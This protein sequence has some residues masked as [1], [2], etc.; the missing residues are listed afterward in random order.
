MATG[1]RA[2]D[3]ALMPSI[4]GLRSSCPCDDTRRRDVWTAQRFIAADPPAVLAS[5]TDPELIMLWA[6]IDF[7]VGGLRGRRLRGGSHAIVNG[8]LAGVTAE[9]EV[10]VLRA[11]EECLELQAHGPVD[12]DVA[13]RFVPERHG[14]T[15]DAE[16]RLGRETG[17]GAR[18]L[19]AATGALLSGGALERALGRLG[20]ELDEVAQLAA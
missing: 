18:V 2:Q 10:D 12:L 11:D 4:A 3:S 20:T 16:I 7:E 19:R 6:P 17:L 1:S 9:F 14:V 5:L 15:V 8:S 13:Y